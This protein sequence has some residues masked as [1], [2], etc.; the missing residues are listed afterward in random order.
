M[1]ME[2][3]ATV[4]YDLK[5]YWPDYI[6]QNISFITVFINNNWAIPYNQFC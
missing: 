3:F 5:K 1:I 4:Q 6:D 2:G